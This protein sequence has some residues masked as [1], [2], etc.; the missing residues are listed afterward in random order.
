MFSN[1]RKH[2][3]YVD[4]DDSFMHTLILLNGLLFACNIA[5]LPLDSLRTHGQSCA[6][7]YTRL[8]HFG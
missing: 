4:D 8:V 2:G 3:T 6:Y 7:I 5:I 1:K